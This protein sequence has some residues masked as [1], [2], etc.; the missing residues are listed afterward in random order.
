MQHKNCRVNC[1]TQRVLL[2]DLHDGNKG[3]GHFLHG[4]SRVRIS[5]AGSSST[6]VV[7]LVL[8]HR[9]K[10]GAGRARRGHG[11]ESPGRN[12]ADTGAKSAGMGSDP[13]HPV[14]PI[15]TPSMVALTNSPLLVTPVIDP[16][17]R[18][19]PPLDLTICSLAP[20][21]SG[22]DCVLFAKLRQQIRQSKR[23]LF[24]RP[25]VTLTALDLDRPWPTLR[26][27][28]AA[29]LN[30]KI[31]FDREHR[32]SAL[33]SDVVCGFARRAFVH[34]SAHTYPA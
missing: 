18:P 4:R 32:R 2:Q 12:L 5:P 8:H 14:G 17:S 13:R 21:A 3:C 15:P 10:E 20:A 26:L 25:P 6:L 22:V 16:S 33:H 24:Q 31:L 7:S 1:L 19:L 27:V 34:A 23:R 29:T 9:W 28:F 11:N 30:L